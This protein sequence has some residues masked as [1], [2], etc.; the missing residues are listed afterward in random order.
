MKV[1]IKAHGEMSEL[2]KKIG[3][4]FADRGILK[5]ALSHTSFVNEAKDG[6]KSN[7]RLEFSRRRRAFGNRQRV[8]FQKISGK[9]RGRALGNET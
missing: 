6:G 1:K 2:E 8:S 5:E 9:Q 4:T 7:E 3:Y